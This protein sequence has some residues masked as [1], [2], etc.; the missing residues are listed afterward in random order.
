MGYIDWYWC[1][2][3]LRVVHPYVTA[4]AGALGYSTFGVKGLM[5]GPLLVC[6]SMVGKNLLME[7]KADLE[8]EE[9]K[10]LL[11]KSSSILEDQ[12]LEPAAQQ[13]GATT[14][15]SAVAE[16]QAE[17]SKVAKA[18]EESP[19]ASKPTKREPSPRADWREPTPPRS[20]A[21]H[22]NIGELKSSSSPGVN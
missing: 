19:P 13:A 18:T 3:R 21:S 7:Y 20:Y 6:F 5:I 17:E 11:R 16:S 2:E 8:K 15:R 12:P 4:L 14:P 9:E 1:E 22:P 10:E